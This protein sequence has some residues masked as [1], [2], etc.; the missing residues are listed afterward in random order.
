MSVDSDYEMHKKMIVNFELK[1]EVIQIMIITVQL[2]SWVLNNS[3][4]IRV[5]NNYELTHMNVTCKTII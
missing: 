5:W 3:D 1:H 2:A 4:K